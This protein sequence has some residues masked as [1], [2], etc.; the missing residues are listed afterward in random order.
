MSGE[1][2]S[3]TNGDNRNRIARAYTLLVAVQDHSVA[4]KRL[5]QAIALVWQLHDELTPDPRVN[6]PHGPRGKPDGLEG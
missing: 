4:D 2:I 3:E 5:D 1:H 6:N